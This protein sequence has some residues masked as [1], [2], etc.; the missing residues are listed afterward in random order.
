MEHTNNGYYSGTK[1][2]EDALYVQTLKSF[3]DIDLYIDLYIDI[4]R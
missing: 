3:Q 1:K 4:Y 2:N